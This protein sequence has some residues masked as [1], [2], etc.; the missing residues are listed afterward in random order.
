MVTHQLQVERRTAKA[1][2]PK[3]NALPL[4]HAT[5]WRTGMYRDCTGMYAIVCFII[6]LVVYF[7]AFYSTLLAN[8]DVHYSRSCIA[9]AIAE[10]C[11]YVLFFSVQGFFDVPG[12]ILAKLCRPT[13][14]VLKLIMSCGGVNICP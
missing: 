5:N 8:K 12:P 3:T 9:L 4:D 14:Y 13:R 7:L 2:R 1:H 11:Y 6:F 10:D